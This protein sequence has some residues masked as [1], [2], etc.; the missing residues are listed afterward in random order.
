MKKEEKTSIGKEIFEFLKVFVI[1]AVAVL[2]FANFIAHPV[3]VVGH[4]MD[5]TLADGEYGFTSVIGAKIG[6]PERNKIV[7]VTMEDPKTGEKAEWVKRIIGM[8]GETIEC[9]DDVIYIDGKA[10]D[11]SSYLNPE[12]TAMQK[13]QFGCLNKYFIGNRTQDGIPIW[14]DWGPITLGEDEY[15]VM[16]DNRTNSKDSRD[17]SVGPVKESQIYGKGVFVLYPFSSFGLK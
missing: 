11:E 16:G 9:K 8:P 1:S 3:T 13:E 10:I 12:Y 17:P 5:P 4:S 14:E 15:F 7:V 2:L 6:K